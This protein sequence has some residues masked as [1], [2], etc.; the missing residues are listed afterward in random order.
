M[1][2]RTAK[3]INR[4]SKVFLA[5]SVALLVLFFAIYMK[6]SIEFKY[7]SLPVMACFIGITWMGTSKAAIM[8]IEEEERS[9][10]KKND[11]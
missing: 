11:N 4:I 7:I 6:G 3:L 10:G 2:L 1:T 5:S 8:A 9:G